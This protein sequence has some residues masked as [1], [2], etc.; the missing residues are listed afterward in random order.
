[1]TVAMGEVRRALGDQARRPQFIETVHGRGYR[2]IAPVAVD[3]TSVDKHTGDVGLHPPPLPLPGRPAIFVGR[4]SECAQLQQWFTKALQGE[5]QMGFI[6]GEPGIDKT[7]LVDTFVAHLTA[8]VHVWVGHGQCID[9][10]GAGEAYLP[11]LEAL[12]RL[13]RGVEADYLVT[14]LRQYAPSW[15][16]QMPGLLSPAERETL[17]RS[18]SGVTQARMRWELAEALEVLTAR[19]PLVL[20][21]E[22]LFWMLPEQKR[23]FSTPLTSLASSTPNPGNSG[24]PRAWCGCGRARGNAMRLASCCTGVQLVHRGVCHC[25]SAR[26]QSGA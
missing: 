26:G 24:L 9:H 25:R 2:F 13:C 22:D 14:L 16:V 20:V 11:I 18:T 3:T 15:L 10:Y 8:T 4:D 17:G 5:R 12:A 19:R 1:L 21:V 7:A 6:A 23:V